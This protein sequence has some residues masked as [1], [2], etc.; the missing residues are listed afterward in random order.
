MLWRGNEDYPHPHQNIH[1][2]I[3]DSCVEQGDGHVT[4]HTPPTCQP[5]QAGAHSPCKRVKSGKNALRM[6]GRAKQVAAMA[7]FS[8][9]IWGMTRNRTRWRRYDQ[10]DISITSR[11]TAASLGLYNKRFRLWLASRSQS[12]L[13]RW[14]LLPPKMY[15]N[16]L[17]CLIYWV[18]LRVGE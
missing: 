11:F 3:T 1:P 6:A 17:R 8:G 2:P 16:S 13:T 12:N 5:W 4:Q 18:C 14:A 7:T 15:P 9:G 10:R